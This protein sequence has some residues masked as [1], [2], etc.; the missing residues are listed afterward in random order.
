MV[1]SN[2]GG[3]AGQQ[4]WRRRRLVRSIF[5]LYTKQCLD[6]R[7]GR[8]AAGR[9]LADAAMPLTELRETAGRRL[10]RNM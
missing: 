10:Q 4:V 3:A 2:G 7:N 8:L 6:G 5:L 1:I 9:E